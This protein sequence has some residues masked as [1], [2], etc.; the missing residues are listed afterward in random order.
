VIPCP[1]Y[2]T[3]RFPASAVAAGWIGSDYVIT[4]PWFVPR[5]DLWPKDEKTLRAW[6]RDLR[7]GART[8]ATLGLRKM[9]HD[10]GYVEGKTPWLPELEAH[11]E[12]LGIAR[13]VPANTVK[14]FDVDSLLE[15]GHE[16]RDGLYDVYAGLKHDK[17]GKPIWKGQDADADYEVGPGVIQCVYSQLRL[18]GHGVGFVYRF[19]PEALEA[20]RIAV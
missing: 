15:W 14:L 20:L 6:K 19:K 18:D 10:F 2:A 7:Q 16:M 13:I 11:I 12:H 1:Q 17:N 4:A 8:L 5:L 9:G 3:G